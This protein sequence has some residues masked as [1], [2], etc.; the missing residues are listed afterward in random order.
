[1]VK[2]KKEKELSKYPIYYWDFFF[3]HF[4]F[5]RRFETAAIIP[6]FFIKIAIKT[7]ANQTK[8]PQNTLPA[9]IPAVTKT[10]AE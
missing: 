1:L 7:A 6:I 4:T 2:K 5:L 9:V 10:A 3:K 8:P